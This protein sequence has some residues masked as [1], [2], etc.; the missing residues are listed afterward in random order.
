MS[1]KNSKKSKDNDVSV[2]QQISDTSEQKTAAEEQTVR[3]RKR[4]IIK[5]NQFPIVLCIFIAVF[6]SA[7][8]WKIF[9][10]SSIIGTWYYIKNGEYV[11]TEDAP[12]GTNDIPKEETRQYT[13]R[14]CYDFRPDGECVVTLGTMSVK[15]RYNTYVMDKSNVVSASVIYQNINLMYGSYEYDLQG[16]I[17]TGKKLVVKN[18]YDDE[19]VVLKPGEGEFPIEPFENAEYDSRLF[20]EWYDEDLKVTFEFKNDGHML[21]STDDGMTVDHY[22]TVVENGTVLAKYSGGEEQSY[23]Y[24]YSFDGDDVIINGSRAKKVSQ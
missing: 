9:F 5:N 22:Y 11:E 10:D 13:Q 17:F 21:R 1:N 12:I 18:L 14:I 24:S 20:G 19:D 8:V 15:G 3:P 16:N 4:K 7:L 23:S 6:L 2:E